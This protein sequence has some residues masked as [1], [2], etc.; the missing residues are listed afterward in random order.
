MK[1]LLPILAFGMLSGCAAVDAYL[2]TH[3]D[4]VEY[5]M[6]TEIRYYAHNSIVDCDDTAVAKANASV[7]A[8]KVGVYRAYESDIPH[9]DDSIKASTALDEMAQGLKTRYAS[10][11][12]VSAIYCKLKFGGIESSATLIQQVQGKRPR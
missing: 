12:K 1:K 11:D 4:P 10:T 7:L 5:H 6:I 3:F 8:Y 9:N 2:M